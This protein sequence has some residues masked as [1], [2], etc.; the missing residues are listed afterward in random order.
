[1]FIAQV[2]IYQNIE[3]DFIDQC[4]LL[5]GYAYLNKVFEG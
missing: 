2:F 4:K 1:M 3:F 5:V